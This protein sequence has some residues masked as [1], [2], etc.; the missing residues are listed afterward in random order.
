MEMKTS[1][2]KLK[3]SEN[4]QGWAQMAEAYLVQKDLD[5]AIQSD[6][7]DTAD[8]QKKALSVLTLLC[9]YGPANHIRGCST[10]FEAWKLFKN[11]YNADGFT[12][13]YLL[14]QKYFSTTQSDFGSVEEYI[15]QL[16]S[17]LDNLG[18]QKLDLP[19]EVKIS[20][21][22]SNLEE[23]FNHFVAQVT[24]NLRANPKAYTWESLTANL[25]DEAKRL[26]A[27]D[28]NGKTINNTT[29]KIRKAAHKGKKP[30]KAKKSVIFCKY[31]KIPG[32]EDKD[33]YFLHPKKAPKDWIHHTDKK[34]KK[35]K[36]K[37]GRITK[38]SG[39]PE[40][41]SKS[42]REIRE[43]KI[44]HLLSTYKSDE[45]EG[46]DQEADKEE[47]LLIDLDSDKEE[48][49]DLI[50][51]DLDK[52]VRITPAQN[53]IIN[54]TNNQAVVDLALQVQRALQLASG[55]KV[56]SLN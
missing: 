35:D 6:G 19:E 4:Y 7:Q 26:D 22:L 33:C 43:E 25:L 21:L 49:E 24:Q 5:K 17:I 45:S 15:S 16:K 11:L 52:E 39:T 30:W 18:A 20:W 8:I 38:K 51:M 53:N 29:G 12:S 40:K 46:S 2:G 42:K 27:A 44:N 32:H 50:S 56:A 55:R 13:K 9:E 47:Q 37:S 1:V 54:I 31:C 14:L 3:G 23:E 41:Q 48:E 34:N 10:A 28:G 36:V